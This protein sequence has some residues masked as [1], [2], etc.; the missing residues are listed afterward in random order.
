[1][2]LYEPS[3]R[4]SCPSSGTVKYPSSNARLVAI[5]VLLVHRAAQI[6]IGV[7]EGIYD[8][9]LTVEVVRDRWDE[10]CDQAGYVVPA[11]AMEELGL[12]LPHLS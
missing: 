11:N 8:P 1:M 10:L 12:L 6:F 2:G 9:D 5:H 3:N 4:G 7:T